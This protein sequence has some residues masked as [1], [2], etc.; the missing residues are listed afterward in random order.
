MRANSSSLEENHIICD[1]L[2]KAKIQIS[3]VLHGQINSRQ[4]S[5]Y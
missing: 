1:L 3:D 4:D 5:V 2:S